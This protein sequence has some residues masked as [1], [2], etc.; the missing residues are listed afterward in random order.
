MLTGSVAGGYIAQATSLGVPFVLRAVV[1]VVMFVLAFVLMRDIG[2]TPVRGAGVARGMRRISSASIEYGWR[3]PA[4]KWV[5]LALAVHRG[6][7]DLCV[8]R[9]AAL[10]A[11]ALRRSRG[12]R[13]RR[14]RRGDRG[15]RTDPRR[16]RGALDQE[17]LRVPDLGVD[18]RDRRELAHPRADRRLRA[19]LGRDRPDRGL[20]L[21]LAASTADP[22]GLPERPDPVAAAGLDPLLRLD[23]RLDGRGRR[24]A[25][26][27]PRR[28][29]S[30]A[31]RARICS[32]PI[33]SAF[34]L[35]F[36]YLSH[37]QHEPADYMVGAPPP[38]E[39]TQTAAQT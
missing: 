9:P 11:R 22:P 19:V 8:L 29:T 6:G 37:R 30:G 34:A 27:R 24:P 13:D 39:P 5:M 18:R 26:A 7:R 17:A 10:S 15:R 38:V 2:F 20:G 33:I 23:A 1:L 32:A 12:V 28:R 36:V 21:A 14:P 4:V 35:P 3:V 31:I 16:G 25:G